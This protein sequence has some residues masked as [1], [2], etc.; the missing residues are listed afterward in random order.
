MGALEDRGCG[1]TAQS[2]ARQQGHCCVSSPHP[3]GGQGADVGQGAQREAG[4]LKWG[5]RQKPARPGLHVAWEQSSVPE[6]VFLPWDSGQRQGVP[7][8]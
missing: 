5:S 2:G 7:V 4:N 1:P 3:G 6:H 8:P